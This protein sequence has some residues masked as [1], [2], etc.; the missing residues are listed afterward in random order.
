[1][2]GWECNSM[3]VWEWDFSRLDCVALL[4]RSKN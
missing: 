2:I 4:E 1:M 3:P